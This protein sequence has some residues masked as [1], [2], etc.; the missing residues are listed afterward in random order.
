MHEA[1]RRVLILGGSSE[2]FA[3][4]ERLADDAGLQVISSFAGRI[5]AL[6]RPVGEMRVGGFGG[7]E[8]LEAYLEAERIAAVVDAT[9]PFASR[10]THNAAAAAHAA[11]VPI[12]HFWRPEWRR[13][14]RDRWTEVDSMAAAAAAIPED[15]SPTFLTTGRSDLAAFADRGDIRF[16]ARVIEPIRPESEDEEWPPRLDFV[17]ARGPF[18]Y[19]DERQLLESRGVRCIVSKNSG[20]DAARAKLDAAG[21]LGV[22]VIM[23]RRPARPAGRHVATPEEALDWLEQVLDPES[24]A[25]A[26]APAA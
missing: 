12:L 3:L 18:M 13:G 25:I 8:G 9:H 15:A 20:G 26:G 22:P 11:A 23:V 5:K 10:M 19:E 1:Q 4:A 6:K 21:D 16:L 2:A 7:V 14:P 24:G 17:Y